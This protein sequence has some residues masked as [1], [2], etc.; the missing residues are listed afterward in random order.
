MHLW[1]G[2]MC[3]AVILLGA[4]GNVELCKKSAQNAAESPYNVSVTKQC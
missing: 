4:H 2:K 1:H 3:A